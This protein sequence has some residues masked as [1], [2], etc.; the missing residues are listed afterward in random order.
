MPI[1]AMRIGTINVTVLSKTQIA[2]DMVTRSILVEVSG[3]CGIR[4]G[5]VCLE[6]GF[7]DISIWSAA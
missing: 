3:N 2:K 4:L 1:V 6:E 5:I 7:S